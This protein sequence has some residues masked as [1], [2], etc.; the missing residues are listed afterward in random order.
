[1]ELLEKCYFSLHKD[2]IIF[3]KTHKNFNNTLI[4]NNDTMSV[5]NL[6][7]CHCICGSIVVQVT[8]LNDSTG[9]EKLYLFK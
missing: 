4:K 2:F 5:N 1:M 9:F 3:K 6:I 7:Q 8:Y